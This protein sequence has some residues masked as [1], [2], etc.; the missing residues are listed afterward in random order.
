MSMLSTSMLRRI[1]EVNQG[2]TLQDLLIRGKRPSRVL[3]VDWGCQILDALAEAHAAGK[4]HGHVSEDQIIASP[5]GR[6]ILLGFGRALPPG[7]W[8][9][10]PLN[11]Q[12]DL[13][14]VGLLLRR[15][16]FAVVLRGERGLGP[17]K[18]DPLLK[19]LAR[20]TF[21]SPSARFRDAG[22]MADALRQAGRAGAPAAPAPRPARNVQPS[23]PRPVLVRLPAPRPEIP[24]RVQ[25]EGWEDRKLAILLLTAAV[26]LMVLLVTA[27][28][29]LL[30]RDAVVVPV[31]PGTLPSA[32]HGPP[33]V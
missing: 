10:D 4:V 12:S 22:E 15:L 21:P 32:V 18:R 14:A 20:A 7:N 5:D 31:L 23:G 3:L 13:Y 9:E 16:A 2:P 30:E 33:P 26:L 29:F 25:E 28:W 1:D 17:P 6:L 8:P 11:P 24:R 19:V 27:G